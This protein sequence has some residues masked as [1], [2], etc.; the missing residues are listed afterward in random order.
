MPT[1]VTQGLRYTVWPADGPM[2]PKLRLKLK[3][4]LISLAGGMAGL[5]VTDPS[6][7]ATPLKPSQWREMLAQAQ[8]AAAA[9]AT[10]ATTTAS[11][12]SS[13]SSKPPPVVVLD[14]RNDYEWDAGHFVGAARPAEEEFH[15]TPVGVT[16]TDIPEPLRGVDKDTA[17]MVRAGAKQQLYLGDTWPV[18]WPHAVP[19]ARLFVCAY[20]SAWQGTVIGFLHP[21]SALS[22]WSFLFA[23]SPISFSYFFF[24]SAHPTGGLPLR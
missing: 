7:R 12:S 5:P 13:S 10:T 17:V 22:P 24:L 15:E 16:D 1:H 2:Y 18:T 11:S 9:A 4:N 14:V 6:A 20:P 3:P 8:Q 23:L 21:A 19:L